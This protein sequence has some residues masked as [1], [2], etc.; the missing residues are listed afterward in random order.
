MAVAN[1][2]KS[3]SK[4]A[5][6]GS[7]KSSNGINGVN[8]INE[9]NSH[10][11]VPRRRDQSKKKRSLLTRS[12]NIVARLLTWYSILT[13][14]FR[15]P[16]TLDACT[17]TSPKICK[18]YFQVKTAISPHVTPYYNAYAAP[19]VDIARPYYNTLDRVLVSP[20][21]AYVVKYGGP[22]LAQAR[23]FG[24]AQWEKN[25]QPQLAYYQSLAKNKYDQTVAPHVQTLSGAVAPYYDIARTNA[26]QT[27][28]E[29]LLPAYI[30]VEP[31]AARGYDVA[32]TFT[33]DTAV[34]STVWAWNKTHAFLTTTVW[35]HARDVYVMK[36]EPQL[37]RIGERLGRYKE[38]KYKSATGEGDFTTPKSSFAKPPASTSSS[39]AASQSTLVSETT[40]TTVDQ[41]QT[42]DAK[43]QLKVDQKK[44]TGVSQEVREQAAKTVAEDLE[45]WNGKFT[46]AAEEGAIEIEAAVDEIAARMIQTQA[47]N[48]GKPLVAQLGETVKYALETLEKSIV[49]SLEMNADNPEKRDEALATAIRAAGLEIKDKAQEIRNWRQQYEQEMETAVTS[50]AQ[51]HFGIIEKTRDLA[52]QKIGIKWAW[53]EGITYKDWKKYHEMKA[54][55]A[56]WTQELKR[57]ISTHPGLLDAQMVGSEIEDE[58][59]AIA[60]AAAEEL[61]RLK[62]VATWKAIAGDFSDNFDSD[63]T[64]LA[65]IA[66]ARKAADAAR[67]AE[68]AARSADGQTESSVKPVSEVISEDVLDKAPQGS[69]K[70]APEHDSEQTETVVV[71]LAQVDN[72]DL[73]TSALPPIENLTAEPTESG[74]SKTVSVPKDVTNT[75]D[76][77]EELPNSDLIDEPRQILE[78]IVNSPD[79]YSKTPSA[80]AD[81]DASATIKPALFGAMAQSVPSRQPIF[82]DEVASSLATSAISLVKSDLPASI[83]SAAQAAYTTAIVGAADHYSRAMSVVSAQISGEPKPVHE[84]MFRSVSNAYLGAVAAANSRLSVAVT[85]ASEGVYGTPTTKWTPNVPTI[86]S[87]DWERVQSI[88]QRNFDNSVNWASEQY[89]S[90]KVALGATDPTP[91]TYLEEAEQKA[92]KLLDQAKHNYFAGLGLAHARYSEFVSAAST[93]VSSL[94]ASP[95]PTNIQE[96][97]TSAASVVSKSVASAASAASEG[98]ESLASSVGDMASDATDYIGDNWDALLSRVSSQVYSAPTP[99]PW[100]QNLYDAADNLASAAGG[101]AA[102]ATDAAGDQVSGATSAAGD[103]ATSATDSISSQYAIVSSLFS[104]LVVGK[105]PSFTESVYSRLAEAYATGV[106]SASSFASAASATAASAASKATDTANS[107]ADKVK[108][109]AKHLKD[110]L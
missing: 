95:T 84:E 28:H 18:P 6:N 12:F 76:P 47:K 91:S 60:Q 52:L 62:Q 7:H 20:G 29:F 109:T 75:A 49:S 106:S 44:P 17:D 4:P 57:L 32:Y 64:E 41:S 94:T 89:E 2:D 78:T 54:R 40:S 45:L 69:T 90:A 100:Y 68:M 92:Q 98:A 1:D 53:M 66:A 36:V 63:T 27:Y 35:P 82:D 56:E 73:G 43:T 97:A 88:A 39:T 61:A 55:F 34:P 93:A 65:A 86:P 99:T 30:F 42:Q 38:K 23:A 85:A 26:L 105:E 77:I 108:D 80:D 79:E 15:C 10:A 83:T 104:E 31:Y 71:S 59:M 87:V 5:S 33:A 110:E 16:P 51:E 102:S 103:Y 22:W 25:V 13:I 19:Y 58:G 21:R 96:S 3:K 11:V 8:G 67:S 37:V 9:I 107:A 46:K 101:Y 24:Q 70:T 74:S 50:A 48:V 81:A 14:L 72:E